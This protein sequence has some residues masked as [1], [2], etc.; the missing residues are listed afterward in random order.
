MFLMKDWEM[1]YTDS[2]EKAEDDCL[3]DQISIDPVNKRYIL[4]IGVD[5][6]ALDGDDD[7]GEPV[8]SIYV[9]RFVFDFITEGVKKHGFR[10]LEYC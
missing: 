5:D 6:M 7:I 4:D 8:D 3:F 9:S 1:F 2:Y 10:Q